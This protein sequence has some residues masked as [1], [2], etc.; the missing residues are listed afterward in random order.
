M[1]NKI[2][3]RPGWAQSKKAGKITGLFKNPERVTG[4]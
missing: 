4:A 2:G 1:V 3:R